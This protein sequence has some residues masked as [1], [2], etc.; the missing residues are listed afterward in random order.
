LHKGKTKTTAKVYDDEE[1]EIEDNT[2]AAQRFEPPTF[3]SS[4]WYSNMELEPKF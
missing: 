4:V 1:L 2:W 3:E